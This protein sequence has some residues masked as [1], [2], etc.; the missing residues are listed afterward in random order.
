MFFC[1]NA[2][3]NLKKLV[4]TTNNSGTTKEANVKSANYFKKI[5]KK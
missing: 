2:R 4:N 3:K 5:T 1:R